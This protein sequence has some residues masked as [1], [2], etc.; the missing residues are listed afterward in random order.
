[1][2]K[3]FNRPVKSTCV[4]YLR[5]LLLLPLP[6]KAVELKPMKTTPAFFNKFY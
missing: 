4:N 6:K 1:M 5:I 2:G 3:N